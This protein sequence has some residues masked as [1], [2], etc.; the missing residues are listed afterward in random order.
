MT[1]SDNDDLIHDQTADVER[2]NWCCSSVGS[3][4]SPLPSRAFWAVLV[5]IT[6]CGGPSAHLMSPD[7]VNAAVTAAPLDLGTVAPGTVL[8]GNIEI[9]TGAG[10]VVGIKRIATECEC[11]SSSLNDF[12]V[13]PNATASIPVTFDSSKEPDFRGQLAI[14]VEGRSASGEVVFRTTIRIKVVEPEPPVVSSEND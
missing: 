12:S 9:S 13:Q 11:I 1:S 4:K 14:P 5:L 2:S 8:E 7:T 6:G 10:R 3:M